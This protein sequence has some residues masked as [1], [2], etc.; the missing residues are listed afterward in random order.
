[1]PETQLV[2]M[3]AHQV[4]QL[5]DLTMNSVRAQ[6]RA[7]LNNIVVLPDNVPSEIIDLVTANIHKEFNLD[8][9]AIYH[10]DSMT[11]QLR[12]SADVEVKKAST[13]STGRIPRPPN[14]FIIYRAAQHKELKAF[15]PGIPNSEICKYW[16]H[17]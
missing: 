16:I 8:W 12:P 13:A 6:L 14:A 5:A 10:A 11:V 17:V 1:M 9:V 2:A 3:A 15:R 4:D 7:G